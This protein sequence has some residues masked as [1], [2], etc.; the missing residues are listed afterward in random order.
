MHYL[1]FYEKS[2]NHAQRER[3]YQATHLDYVKAAARSGDL[4]LAGSLADPID[5]AALLLF[6]ADSPT[7]AER[8]AAGDPYV[9]HGI[10]SRWYV[11][12][13]TTVVGADA[14]MPLPD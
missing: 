9:V 13:W 11:R 5:G 2:P 6:R 3:P 7:V 12:A 1:L 14:A 4:V 8:F 10:I